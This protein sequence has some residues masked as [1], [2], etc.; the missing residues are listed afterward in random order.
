MA[1]YAKKKKES[2]I[3]TVFNNLHEGTTNPIKTYYTFYELNGKQVYDEYQGKFRSEAIAFFESE[4]NSFGGKFNG[5][6]YTL[7]NK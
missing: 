4:A 1:Y 2:M 6:L 5:K 3:R 7:K